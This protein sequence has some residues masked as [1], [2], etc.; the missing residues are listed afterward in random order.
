M[1][2]FYEH[3]NVKSI[4]VTLNQLLPAYYNTFLFTSSSSWHKIF[5]LMVDCL[6]D[7]QTNN[8]GVVTIKRA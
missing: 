8:Y 1:R 2:Y 3:N 4:N 5:R 6:F 7:A